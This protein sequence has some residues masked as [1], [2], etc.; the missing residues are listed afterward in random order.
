MSLVLIIGMVLFR[1]FKTA[2]DV[3]VFVF[4]V[5]SCVIIL[6]LVGW[7]LVLL[8]CGCVV[9][10]LVF[11]CWLVDFCLGGLWMVV[12]VV[13]FCVCFGVCVGCVCLYCYVCFWLC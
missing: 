6:W 9:F 8:V 11:V 10:W 7:L 13:L 1:V 4:L 2:V 12:C 5:F 3:L